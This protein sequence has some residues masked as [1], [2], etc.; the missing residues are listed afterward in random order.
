MDRQ[1]PSQQPEERRFSTAA[2][3]HDNGHLTPRNFET[4]TFE[5][6]TLMKRKID[7]LR[8][9]NWIIKK[10]RDRHD[11]LADIFLIT[12]SRLAATGITLKCQKYCHYRGNQLDQTINLKCE[13]E[14]NEDQN[15]SALIIRLR[16]QADHR[17]SRLV[18]ERFLR[19]LQQS[20]FYLRLD[21]RCVKTTVREL[22]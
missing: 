11:G 13:L 20:R 21:T 19:D 14:V 5:D 22:L 18:T 16:I 3:S 15:P 7:V 8:I 10:R 9:N 4:Q 2:W 1:S 12:L 6:G 17:S